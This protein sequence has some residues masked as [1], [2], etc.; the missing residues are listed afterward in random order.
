MRVL[1]F[2][3]LSAVSLV[4]V[5]AQD[6]DIACDDWTTCNSTSP[7]CCLDVYD[8]TYYCCGSETECCK[9]E[10]GKP[11]CCPKNQKKC[12]GGGWC[13]IEG[14]CCNT[15]CMPKGSVCCPAPR[16]GFC[17]ENTKCKNGKCYDL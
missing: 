6:G 10:M 5:L 7:V 4:A 12:P 11:T 1:K 3:L 15:G 16:G 2:I 17:P 14:D 13:P 9:D 8:F